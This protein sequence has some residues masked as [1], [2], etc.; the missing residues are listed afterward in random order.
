MHDAPQKLANQNEIIIKT[1]NL[2][3]QMSGPRRSN[4]PP[5]IMEIRTSKMWTICSRF[6]K[7]NGARGVQNI[8]E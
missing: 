6:P 3:K 5:S 4:E 8:K 1:N 2:K 7:T